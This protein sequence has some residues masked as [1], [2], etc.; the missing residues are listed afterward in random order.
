MVLHAISYRC[1]CLRQGLTQIKYDVT[2][3]IDA[4]LPN[5]VLHKNTYQK[6]YVMT[7]VS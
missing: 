5:M 7:Y 6:S 2:T 3:Y 1:H 4:N